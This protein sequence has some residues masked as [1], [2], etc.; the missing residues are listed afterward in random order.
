MWET[1]GRQ[2]SGHSKWEVILLEPEHKVVV[3][4]AFEREELEHRVEVVMQLEWVEPEHK[5]GEEMS[6]GEE[7][8]ENWGGKLG[9]D[10]ERK[11]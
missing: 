6:F 1:G 9:V 5:V 3:V 4:M 8:P 7:V 2:A 10:L 11:Y